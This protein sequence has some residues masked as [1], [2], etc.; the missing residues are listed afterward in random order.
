MRIIYLMLSILS[1][2][3]ISC[4]FNN[5]NQEDNVP[6]FGKG[7]YYPI[8]YYSSEDPPFYLDYEYYEYSNRPNINV[9]FADGFEFFFNATNSGKHPWSI[10]IM[11]EDSEIVR[12]GT[13]DISFN[14]DGKLALIS[15][16]VESE[17]QDIKTHLL[18]L[19]GKLKK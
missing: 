5:T 14:L 13:M 11:N 6:H 17:K 12:V 3:I 2:N 15:I 7:T 1:L 16:D 8:A 4:N 9:V 18:A 10:N 19:E